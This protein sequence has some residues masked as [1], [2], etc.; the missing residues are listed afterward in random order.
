[1]ETS[2]SGVHRGGSLEQQGSDGLGRLLDRAVVASTNAI[3][4]TD[5]RL[6]DNPIVY[7]NPAF[8]KTTGY[9]VEEALGY[10]CRFLQGED[11]DQPALE[12]LRDAVRDGRECRVVLRNY[13]KDGTLFWNE[14]HVAPMRD[15]GGNLTHFIGVQT[16]VTALKQTEEARE[17]L[18]S[19]ERAARL[20][21][22]QA[23]R[24]TDEARVLLDTILEQAPV[25]LA[26]LDT[27]L[28]YFLIND[29]LAAVN[30][31]PAEE[32]LGR[33][34]RE[35]SPEMERW[36]GR[37]FRRVLETGQ[38]LV[39]VEI[40]REA[41]GGRRTSVLASYYPVRASD[42]QVLGVG[43][44]VLDITER[45][46][47]EET[48]RRSEERFRSLVQNASDVI[49]V[50]DADGTIGYVSPA[51]EK[52]LGYRPE[53]MVGH[54]AIRFLYPDD[55]EEGS[56][57]FAK[58][59]SRPGVHPAIEFRVPH[60]NG[61]WRYLETVMNNLLD[62]P[63]VGGVV[64]NQRDI[65]RRR[66]AEETMRRSED[67]LR[68]AVEATDLGTWDFNPITGDLRWD[69]RCKALFG[70]PPEAEVDYDVFLAGLHPEDRERTDGIVQRTLDPESGG[71][72]DIEYRTVGLT[73]G[74]ERWVAAR[75]QAYF[76]DAG[77]AYRF[78]GT[79]L[80]ITER[81]RT[82]EERDLLLAREQLARVEAVGTRRRLA[83]LAAAG[84]TLS[85]SLDYQAT[86]EKIAHLVVPELADWCVVDILEEDGS[87]HQLAA[88][89]ADP[90]GG[91]LLDE[92]SRHRRFG[93]D[94]PG[95]VAQ[96]LRT[97]RSIVV[98]ETSDSLLG[99]R[100]TG[101]EHLGVLRRLGIH[102][103]MS[104][105]LIARRRTLG[106]MTLVSADPGRRYGDEDLSLAEGL[107]YR[108]ALAVDNARLYRE[109]SRIAHTLQRSLLP[110][111]PEMRGIEVGVE[112]LPVGEE[113]EVGGDFYDL[114]E[115]KDGR[116]L[117]VIGDVCGKGAAAAAVTALT[118]YTVRAVAMREDGPAAVLGALNEAMRRQLDDDQFCTVACAQLGPADGGFG[119]SV[120]R[121]GHPAPL[122]VRA[123]G[124][125]EAIAP[126]GRA[127]GVFPDAGLEVR[128]V[129]LG[130]GDAAVFYTDGLT[131]ARGPDGSFFGEERLWT[132]LRS[133]AGLS[134]P[135]IAER[136]RDVAMEYGEGNPRDD[137]AVLVLRVPE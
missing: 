70:L 127:L 129:H 83:L 115:T 133:C 62:A 58:I 93:E 73:D 56:R 48:L 64:L 60:K 87:V 81:K 116:W 107:A 123:G 111:L 18:L 20:D 113:N 11:R 105:P 90:D 118:R 84:T 126:P 37:Y 13:R 76:D 63:S 35:V 50:V 8:E 31:I 25:G 40:T 77:R 38:P 78:I 3:V 101:E 22:Q 75:G 79:V 53:E 1:M 4:I 26:F 128:R 55:L 15:E 88:A 21:A 82:E 65:T 47:A 14:L 41:S 134:A 114:I 67:R 52:V 99:E 54:N 103:Y 61:S 34:M 69:E 33:D 66:L 112:Y 94:T 19:H 68:L 29:S 96:V 39:D 92:L 2:P 100:T 120:A 7:L 10:N 59:A 74:V 121:G 36:A 136:L 30:G 91:S 24:R 130:P 16:D 9:S 95:T 71:Q 125:I 85:A 117:A 119:L 28:R 51:V 104:V 49:M 89:H 80:D 108:C 45:K 5:P 86:V 32:H 23:E 6:P 110:S 106:A 46:E 132:L 12:E 57:I 135:A 44:A 124:S 122:L 109:R 137:L 102:S 98:S 72:Y 42:G 27:D 17:H 131:E 97:G 43:C